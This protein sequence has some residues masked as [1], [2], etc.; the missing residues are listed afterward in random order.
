MGWFLFH[1]GIETAALDHEVIDDP[2]KTSAVVEAFFYVSQ[3]AFY[4][5]GCFF[6]VQFNCAIAPI[7]LKFDVRSCAHGFT[8]GRGWT[9][10]LRS[11]AT[12][13][14]QRRCPKMA[15]NSQR[16]AGRTKTTGK[17]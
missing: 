11:T 9:R 4:G 2:V 6:G 15:E 16:R 8:I 7:S 10:R 3:E 12:A 17:K 13:K 1:V 14:G 5:F